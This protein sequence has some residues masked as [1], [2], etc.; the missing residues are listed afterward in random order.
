[1]SENENNFEALRHLL[2]LKRHEVPPP[3]YF[4]NFSDGVLARIHASEAVRELP[5]LLRLLQ[6][7]ESRPAFPVAFASTLCF[8]LLFGIVSVEQNPEMASGQ[9]A[10]MGNGSA[11]ASVTPT[12][13]LMP[14]GMSSVITGDTNHPIDL[15]SQTV[16]NSQPNSLLQ[17]VSFSPSGN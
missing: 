5:W 3:G 13:S 2:A 4:E 9:A 1:M 14:V 8:L 6:A 15:S 16:F 12:S 10:F 11:F 7:F 17:Q